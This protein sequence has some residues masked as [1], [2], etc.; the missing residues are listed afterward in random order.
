M[1]GNE[2]RLTEADEDAMRAAIAHELRPGWPGGRLSNATRWELTIA[3][4][5]A[6]G[7]FPVDLRDSE[8][9]WIDN[10]IG[11]HELGMM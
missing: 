10:E 5:R 8:R 2:Y 1:H 3:A 9:Q 11:Q 6:I 7:C 4:A